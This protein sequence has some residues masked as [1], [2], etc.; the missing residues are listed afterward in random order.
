MKRLLLTPLIIALSSPVIAE[1]FDSTQL[2]KWHPVPK[3]N[4][5]FGL[6]WNKAEDLLKSGKEKV[7]AKEDHNFVRKLYLIRKK[8]KKFFDHLCKFEK[9]LDSL[10]IK[11]SD[12]R[13]QKRAQK[14]I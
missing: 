2:K 5:A 8:Y 13:I 11:H 9:K 3:N 7:E 12:R 14:I 10:P 1:N 4:I 6:F